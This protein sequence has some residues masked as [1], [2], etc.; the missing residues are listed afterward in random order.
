[1]DP[2]EPRPRSIDLME[3]ENSILV[4]IDFQE[5]LVPAMRD[6]KTVV[7]NA[8]RLLDA[9]ERFSIPVVATEQYPQGLGPTVSQIAQRITTPIKAKKSFSAFAAT[10]R[11]DALRE[12]GRVNALVCGIETHVCVLQTVLDLMADGWQTFVAVDA[13]SSRF[14]QDGKIALSRMEAC[15]ATL[16]TTETALFEWCATAD[17]PEFK[18]VSNLVREVRP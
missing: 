1:M 11:F 16:T 12:S 13:V 14:K 6:S 18:G 7:F 9:A 2:S 17:H 10:D 15:G 8:R 3:P 5:R 4:V